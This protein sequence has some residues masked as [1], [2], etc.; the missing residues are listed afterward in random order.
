M[1]A[2]LAAQISQLQDLKIPELREKYQ[3]LFGDESRTWNKQFLFR[4]IAWRLQALA[5]GD[6]TER[7]YQRAM[8]LARDTDL[9]I[10]PPRQFPAFTTARWKSDWRLP[11]P[12]TLLRRNYGGKLH[13]VEVLSD[14]FHYNGQKFRS[15][16]AVAFAIS[17][18][19]WNGFCFFGLKKENGRG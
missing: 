16:S 8:E 18:T 19:R 1:N 15:L 14:G 5:E 11:P 6:L 12:G 17:G 13:K 4:R 3:E 9:K 2:T 7:A 10:R